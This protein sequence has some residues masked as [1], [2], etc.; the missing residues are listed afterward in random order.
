MEYSVNTRPL[1][2]RSDSESDFE[3]DILEVNR[4]EDHQNDHVVVT[5]DLKPLF[6]IREPSDRY[7]LAYLIFY[8]LGMTTL[9][10]W[11]FFITADD[12]WMYKFRNASSNSTEDDIKKTSLQAG[13]TAYLSDASWVAN[14]IF[15]LTHG[16]SAHQIS[17]QIRMIG[18]LTCI[19]LL[20]GLTTAFVKINTDQWQGAFFSITLVTVVLLNIAS[21]ILQGGLFGIVGKFS[22]RYITAVVGGQALGGIVA[23]LAEILSLFVGAS[24]TISAFVYFMVAN[25]MLVLSLAAYWILSSS[26]FFRFHMLD[27][28]EVSN[29][30]YEPA[31]IQASETTS[32][33]Q[34]SYKNILTKI[35]PYG[36]SVWM[37]FLVTLAMYPAV[38]VLINS[39]EKGNGN[40]WNDVYFV[41]VIGYLIFSTCDYM[42]RIFAG[43][44]QR[45]RS[46]GW[47][48]V[49]LSVLRVVFVPLLLLCNAQPRSHLPVLIQSDVYYIIIIV[50][51]GLSNGYLANITLICVPR[52]VDSA[53]QETASSMMAAF[54]GIGLACGS[55]LSLLMVNAL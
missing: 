43:L 31:V 49:L 33:R 40:R 30:Q 41:P 4:S 24:S 32:V 3:D 23:A 50:L 1:L 6:K 53:E 35:W 39:Q 7:N 18:S 11:N 47:A 8:L 16:K 20:F 36:F 44:L 28:V 45:P 13:F 29:M 15:A 17:L 21:A 52:I 51:F 48:V 55:A 10:P 2:Q 42:G 14:S 54:L 12:Y 27:K 38:T 9:L 19:L 5:S 22:S 37:T 46:K 34:I 25:G 26:V